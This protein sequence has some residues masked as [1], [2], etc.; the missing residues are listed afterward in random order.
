MT[1]QPVPKR[2]FRGVWVQTVGRNEYRTKTPSEVRGYFLYMLDEFEKAGFNAFIFQVRPQADA[3]YKSAFEPWSAYLTGQQGLAPSPAWDPLEFLVREC[4]RRNMEFHAWINPYRVTMSESEIL[5]PTHVYYRHPEWFVTYGGKIYFDPGIPDC[6]NF[7]CSVVKDIVARYD[8][9]A[10]HIDDYF[11]PYPEKGLQFP[12]A[13]SF[14]MYGLIDGFLPYQLADWRRENINKLVRDLKLTIK[15]LKPWVQLGIAPFGIYRNKSNTRDGSGSNTSGLQNFDDLYADVLLW[16][17][18]GWIDYLA[19]QLYWAIGNKAADYE[20][21]IHWWNSNVKSSLLYIGQHVER[22]L[23]ANS[24]T[25]KSQFS[26]KMRLERILP[27]VEGNCFWY[28]Y[29]ILDNYGGIADSLQTNYHRYPA[30]IPQAKRAEKRNYP[31]EPIELKAD[32]M[33]AGYRLRWKVTEEKDETSK[34]A[35]YCIYRFGKGEKEN[36]NDARKII[37]IT[38]NRE[39]YLPRPDGKTDYKYIVTSVNRLHN[40]SSNGRYIILKH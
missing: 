32:W 35:Y 3:F 28:G 7:V 31:S 9:D 30:L 16:Q 23:T 25:R 37:G 15:N 26:E 36:F 2:E 11:Y 19:P 8:I 27:N 10:I 39:Y 12:D 24:T 1:A 4:H 17:R 14:R 40:E 6:R 22:S 20:S 29:A 21:L 33:P 5:A 38:R 13:N 34:P 18:K